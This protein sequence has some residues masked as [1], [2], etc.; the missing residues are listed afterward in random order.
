MPKCEKC[1]TPLE[2][3]PI[4]KRGLY[5]DWYCRKCRESPWLPFQQLGAMR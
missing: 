5:G 1:G 3:T 2:R 4:E